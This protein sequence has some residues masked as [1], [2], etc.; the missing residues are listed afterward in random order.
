LRE[1]LRGDSPEKL[2]VQHAL[3]AAYATFSVQY[4]GL[5]ASFF[6]E[7]FLKQ[8]QVAEQLA[9]LLTP[10]Q[11]PDKTVLAQLWSAQFGSKSE[12]DLDQPLTDFLETLETEIKAK[13]VLKPFVD[14]R[15]FDQL[16][17]IAQRTEDQVYLQTQMHQEL[18]AIRELIAQGQQARDQ[19][20]IPLQRPLASYEQQYRQHLKA[21]YAEDA[22]YYIPLAGE[23]TEAAPLKVKPKALQ[24][25][26]RHRRK[27]KAEYYELKATEQE[28]KRIK[29]DT[30]RQGV[31][32]YAC[33]ILLGD[34]LY[35]AM[36]DS[37]DPYSRYLYG[38]TRCNM[39][40][41][42]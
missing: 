37:A 20:R 7:H 32:K 26:L 41:P 19:G 28:I 39:P 21:R 18:M 9:K 6:D 40:C 3:A 42:S 36:A 27:T 17:V 29:L 34:P 13:S 4:P 22:P 2:A 8:T 35:L 11:D 31:D 12:V 14:S 38:L 23:T 24:L 25:A 30:L 33:I 1:K 16:Y 15:A 5:V 10:D